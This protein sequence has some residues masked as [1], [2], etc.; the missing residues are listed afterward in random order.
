MERAAGA[1][2]TRSTT[3]KAAYAAALMERSRCGIAAAITAESTCLPIRPAMERLG[4]HA[5]LMVVAEA[6]GMV[7]MRG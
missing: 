7:I 5:C 3:V 6:P 2:C 1:R 4:V